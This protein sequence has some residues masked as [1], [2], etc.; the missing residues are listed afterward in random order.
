MSM[1]RP[2]RM[3]SSTE[4]AR[5]Q[6]AVDFTRHSVAL[7]GFPL[8]PEIEALFGRCVKGVLSEEELNAAVLKLAHAAP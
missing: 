1:H 8:D 7:E 6:E 5:R 4:R 2:S 3:I